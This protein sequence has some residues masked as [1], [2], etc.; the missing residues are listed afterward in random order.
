MKERLHSRKI[1][2][3]TFAA[4]ENMILVEGTLEDE[5]F[6]TPKADSHE[7]TV[8]PKIVHYLVARMTLSLPELKIVHL[9]A[10]MPVVPH[11]TCPEIKD[12]VQKLEGMEIR[13]G[14]TDEVKRR[15][16]NTE[17]CLHLMNLILSMGSAAVQGMW[18][19]YAQK[20]RDSGVKRPKASEEMLLDTCWVWRQ[21]GPFA[22]RLKE[23]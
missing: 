11:A 14:F 16:G 7:E 23:K 10:D 2:I 6:R 3:D 12:A 17:G 19:Y 22:R 1:T 5:R 4:G 13:H 8:V 20:S 21:D 18:S 15:F 9:E